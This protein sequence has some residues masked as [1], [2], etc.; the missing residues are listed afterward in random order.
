MLVPVAFP[1]QQWLHECASLLHYMYISGLVTEDLYC[2]VVLS[3]IGNH[4]TVKVVNV[5]RGIKWNENVILRSEHK[6]VF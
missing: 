6:L 5:R 4:S 1:W 2:T 3:E